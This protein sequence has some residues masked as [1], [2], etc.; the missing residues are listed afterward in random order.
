MFGC[1]VSGG[2]SGAVLEFDSSIPSIDGV[3]LHEYTTRLAYSTSLQSDVGLH[4]TR[5]MWQNLGIQDE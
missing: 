2:V 5:R 4:V 3:Q 1:L